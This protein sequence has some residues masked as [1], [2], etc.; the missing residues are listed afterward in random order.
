[1]LGNLVSNTITVVLSLSV[2]FEMAVASLVFL[3]VI[4]K[5]EYF[6]NA[7]IFGRQVHAH[8]WELL[9]AMLVMKASF[10]IGGLVAAPIFYADV[11]DE[12]ASQKLV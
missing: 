1:M 8:A 7:H 3:V 5:L 11:K 12:L 2:S 6:L 9:L 10:G 4:H